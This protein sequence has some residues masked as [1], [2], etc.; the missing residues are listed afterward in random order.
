MGV[1]A[2]SNN[3]I[4]HSRTKHVTVHY[5][6]IKDVVTQGEINLTYVKTVDNLIGILTKSLSDSPEIVVS[7]LVMGHAPIES[8]K[9]SSR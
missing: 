1:I 7:D 2:L 3:S 6:Y 4:F 5:H 8:L 9:P